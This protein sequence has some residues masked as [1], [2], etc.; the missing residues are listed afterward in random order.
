MAN[1]SE[2]KLWEE[3]QR[4]II[5]IFEKKGLR[6]DLQMLKARVM[7]YSYAGFL[8]REIKEIEEDIVKWPFEEY[9]DE[10][11]LAHIEQLDEEEK[12]VVIAKYGIGKEGVYI[13]SKAAGEISGISSRKIP[14]INKRAIAR[15]EEIYR[16]NKC[17][18][19]NSL[20]L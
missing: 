19:K 14:H 20:S 10:E 17:N 12:R 4:D 8:H 1:K 3:K 7:G 16:E 5:K 18:K 6:P 11:L 9:G 15:L 2:L 13:S